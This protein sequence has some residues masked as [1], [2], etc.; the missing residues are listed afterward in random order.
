MGWGI[1]CII[2]YMALYSVRPA[3]PADCPGIARVQ[4]DSYRSAYQGFFPP[5]YLEQF[6]CA[7]QAADW[8]AWLEKFP[9]DL[10]LVAVDPD[11]QVLGYV[12]ARAGRELYPGYDSEVMAIHVLPHIAAITVCILVLAYFPFFS[13]WLPHLLGYGK[14]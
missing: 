12:L 14:F 5:A 2:L 9:Q 4:V 10:L 8:A 7:E 1:F 3:S 6:S 11:G 13:T